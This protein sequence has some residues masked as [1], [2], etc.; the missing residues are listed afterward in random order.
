MIIGPL[1]APYFS[2][3]DLLLFQP[4]AR[5]IF[6]LGSVICPQPEFSFNY[7]GMP[8]AVCYRCSIAILGLVIARGLHQPG[9]W[10]RSWSWRVRW[11]FLAAMVTWLTID[12]QFTHYGIWPANIP[13]QFVHGLF[14]GISV[15]GIWYGVLL[16]LD[17][18][19]EQRTAL[20]ADG[21]L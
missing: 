11:V 9:G 21:I 13:L 18:R 19:S 7:G 8:Y 15:G 1:I 3:I 4:T 16:C 5:V 20:A 17:K 10:M 2:R 14:Y 12:V 6:W